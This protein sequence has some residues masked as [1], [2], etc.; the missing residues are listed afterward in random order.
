MGSVANEPLNRAAS[1]LSNC[2]LYHLQ[3]PDL[4][5]FPWESSLQRR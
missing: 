2:P 4:Q 3:V 1:P 5:T